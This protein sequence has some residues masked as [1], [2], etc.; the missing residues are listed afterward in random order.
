MMPQCIKCLPCK[1]KDQ[2]LD[3]QYPCKSLVGLSVLSSLGSKLNSQTHSQISRNKAESHGGR[4]RDQLL[5][6]TYIGTHVNMLYVHH[7]SQ[8]RT[9]EI[10]APG[11]AHSQKT[12][13]CCI[14]ESQVKGL[15]FKKGINEIQHQTTV[16][17]RGKF[18]PHLRTPPKR[19]AFRTL[20]SIW[21]L[22]TPVPQ[23]QKVCC[24]RI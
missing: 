7:R 22:N 8:K 6:S 9:H 16:A 2:S 1:C 24:K 20:F 15:L 11:R 14:S 13:L 18:C 21:C 10:G 23:E 17:Y 4:T 19:G 3:P 12:L 5:F